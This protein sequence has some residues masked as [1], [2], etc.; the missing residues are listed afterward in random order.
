MKKLILIGAGK[1]GKNYVTTLHDFPS[2]N[3]I[4]ANKENWKS[5]VDNGCDGVF[6]C[7]QPEYHIEI[8]R[9]VLQKNIPTMIEK[10]ICFSSE[11]VNSLKEFSAPILVNHIHLF[12]TAYQHLKFIIGN[13]ISS[14]ESLGFNKGPERAYSSL[15]DYGSHDVAMILDLIGK[16]P[17][18]IN[19]DNIKTKTGFLYFI[20]M[21]FDN[22]VTKSLV[23][24][25]GHSKIRKLKVNHNGLLS[26]YDDKLQSNIHDT[27]LHNAIQ[28]F[29][30][31]INGKNDPRLGINLA[32]QV[33]QILETYHDLTNSK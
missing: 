12:S 22:I 28:V 23:G 30:Q 18:I 10:P 2:T 24:N 8:A 33:T 29:L 3:L 13:N 7:T 5:L 32:C 14:I 11:E 26:V 19:I 4:I 16:F 6:I 27:P 17:N 25:G 20:E 31:A 21:K 1:W 9:Y 15:W